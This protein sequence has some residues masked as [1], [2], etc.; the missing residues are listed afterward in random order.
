MGIYAVSLGPGDPGLITVKG[1]EVLKSADKI[2]FPGSLFGEEKRTSYS[3][4]IL[5]HYKLEE[6]KLEGFYLKMNGNA[7]EA[8][9]VYEE[10]FRK[11]LDLFQKGLKLVFVSEGDISFYSTFIYILYKLE[12]S[13]IPVNIVPGISSIMSA[14]AEGKF[15][16]ALQNEKVAILPRMDNVNQ[17]KRH[18]MDFETVILIKFRSVAD[19]LLPQLR[20]M[21]YSFLYCERL[22]TAQ[23]Y[24]TENIEELT[25]REIPYFSLLIIKRK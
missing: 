6:E 19:V 5:R 1:L 16:L 13:G 11:A 10:V 25:S 18:L 23:Q 21:S 2:F 24:I 12:K 17:L 7:S 3:L 9:A 4:E 15:P 14:G 22:G 8:D 20:S